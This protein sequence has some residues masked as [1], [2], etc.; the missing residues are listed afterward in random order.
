MGGA[1]ERL[2]PRAPCARRRRLLLRLSPSARRA[3]AR[4]HACL[5]SAPPAARRT[6]RERVAARELA[7]VH[8][9]LILAGTLQAVRAGVQDRRALGHRG[10]LLR[11][12]ARSAAVGSPAACPWPLAPLRSPARSDRP[13]P[14]PWQGLAHEPRAACRGT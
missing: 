6:R 4:A 13:P 12:R 14:L 3:A 11:A 9:Q 10:G 5:R 2:Q 7:V 8:D 1:R